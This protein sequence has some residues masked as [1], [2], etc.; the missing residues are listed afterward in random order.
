MKIK[1]NSNDN[2][3][4]NKMLKLHK[5]T[6]IVRPVFEEEGKYYPQV[7]LDDYLYEV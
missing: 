5:L 3:P 7:F 6:V 2:F 4:S 1:F